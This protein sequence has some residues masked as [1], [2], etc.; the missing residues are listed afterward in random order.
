MTT[1]RALT[2]AILCLLPLLAF[3]D[4]VEEKNFPVLSA[5]ERTAE[6]ARL[7]ES[8]SALTKLK[9]PRLS[10]E[11]ISA[12][13]EALR[14]LYESN[15]AVREMTDGALR[16]SHAYI[17]YEVKSGGEFLAA[18]WID[19]AH[20][21]NNIID[22]YG[23]GK[24]PRYPAI[25]A[26]SFDVKSGSY[27]HLLQTVTGSLAEERAPLFFQPSMRYALHLLDLNHRDE[28]GRF[29]PMESGENAAAIRHLAGIKWSSYPYSVIIVPGSGPDRLSWA[30]SPWSKLRL[31]LAVRRF[32]QGK[33]PLILVSGGYVHPNQTPYCE[34]IEMKKSLIADFGVPPEAIIVDP[35]ARHTTTNLRNAARL[36][37]RYRIPFD[38]TGLIT[39]DSY[40]SSYI[41]GDEFAKRNLE[42]L[43][44]QPVKIG[45]RVSEFDLEFVPV[46][47]SMQVDPMQ[48]LDP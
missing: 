17:R 29:E 22:V 26:V 34:A 6:V 18:A 12:A 3:A 14:H 13:A 16:H 32:R 7:V 44:Y 8:D 1:R 43:G 35:H 11:E 37:Q 19:A 2:V 28:A 36:M 23:E 47:D 5:I 33:A 39:T 45:K 21:I 20:G 30:L 15:K 4:A 25:D 41:G 27:A 31:E 48:P 9:K 38:R 40:H 10:E 24:A 46:I 42:E